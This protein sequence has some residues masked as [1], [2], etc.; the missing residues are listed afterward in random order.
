MGVTLILISHI[1]AAGSTVIFSGEF[2]QIY[3]PNKK[4]VGEIRESGGLYQVYKP[5]NGEQANATNPND[6]LTINELHQ[7]LG[8]V[9]IA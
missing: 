8:H 5:G 9:H 3:N 2:C 6:M 1:A 7:C 4:R